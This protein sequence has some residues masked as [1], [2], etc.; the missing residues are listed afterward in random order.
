MCNQQKR[1][2][3]KWV[4]ETMTGQE[5]CIR[6]FVLTVEKNVKYHS[7]QQRE[8]RSIVENAIKNTDHRDEDLEDISKQYLISQKSS[9]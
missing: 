5:Q 3:E 6:L 4:I 1:S 8:G 7:S 2:E 9:I